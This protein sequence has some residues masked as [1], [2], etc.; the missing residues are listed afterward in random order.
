MQL[1]IGTRATG[2]GTSLRTA[3]REPGLTEVTL[4]NPL[5]SPRS[6]TALG[7]LVAVM[8]IVPIPVSGASP[9]ARS[10]RP[11]GAPPRVLDV[12]SGVDFDA[13]GA[14]LRTRP[15]ADLHHLLTNVA[16]M[17]DARSLLDAARLF[18]RDEWGAEVR[19]PSGAAAAARSEGARSSSGDDPNGGEASA[20]ELEYEEESGILAWP[21]SVEDVDGDGGHDVL[22]NSAELP[23]WELSVEMLAGG[24]G[25]QLW[26]HDLEGAWD[27]FGFPVSDLDGDGA[28]DLLIASITIEDETYEETC[29]PIGRNCVEHYT[30]DFVWEYRAVSGTT[31][32]S[33]WSREFAGDVDV[34]DRFKSGR[35]GT[36]WEYSVVGHNVEVF[37]FDGGDHDDDGVRDLV[38]DAFDVDES[39][40]YRS[41]GALGVGYSRSADDLSTVTRAEVASGATGE[42]LLERTTEPAAAFAVL[43]PAGDI[44]GDGS[45]DLVWDRAT[46]PTGSA[47]CVNLRFTRRCNDQYE[48]EYGISYE[49]IDGSTLEPAWT[50]TVNGAEW[51]FVEPLDA[52]LDGD[53]KD[54]LWFYTERYDEETDDYLIE[55]GVV[56]GLDGVTLWTRDDA[57][58]A[59]PTAVG[60]LDGAGSQDILLTGLEIWFDFYCDED[61][62]YV[63]S[64]GRF[65]A[66]RVDGGTGDMIE[67][68]SRSVDLL[69]SEDIFLSYDTLGDADGDRIDDVVWS[70]GGDAGGGIAI[71]AAER[72]AV[73]GPLYTLDEDRL[74]YLSRSGDLDGDAR[75]DV[76]HVVPTRPVFDEGEEGELGLAAPA[77]AGAGTGSM[78]DGDGATA[79][80]GPTATTT[81][82]RLSDAGAL[83]SFTED[84]YFSTLGFG[85]DHDADGADDVLRLLESYAAGVFSSTVESR[86]GRDMG[87]RWSR[88]LQGRPAE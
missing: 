49:A 16:D 21:T 78:L 69:D 38:F 17:R 55:N 87:S 26:R 41:R 60:Q 4:Q 29:N 5:T 63:E 19:A 59:G 54:D 35:F 71:G 45:E 28:A 22:V 72:A 76:F 73:G 25:A 66:Q 52:D 36:R 68:T 77:T 86:R 84:S 79:E 57:A 31:G 67:D 18:V 70:I 47:R 48:G 56:S 42:T 15:G 58:F 82:L 37:A 24:G 23:D 30:A 80:A 32:S 44:V 9:T 51:G 33:L 61:D 81:A 40:T 74:A 13:E 12:V 39:F 65:N 14:R 43:F 85:G 3:P 50:R 7:A 27:A 53:D 20:E 62:C 88:L 1:H 83:W 46:Y 11:S 64:G 10:Q 6:S 75:A 2:G 8:L 34:T